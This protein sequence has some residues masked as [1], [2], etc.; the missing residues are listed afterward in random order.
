[1]NDI[2]L[3]FKIKNVII[4]ESEID[5][6]YKFIPTIS[7]QNRPADEIWFDLKIGKKYA[8]DLLTGLLSEF[9]E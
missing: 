3:K 2:T 6:E 4:S 9:K 5:G 8:G 1:M 7:A